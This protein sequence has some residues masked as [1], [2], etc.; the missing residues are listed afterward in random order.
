MLPV[1]DDF[2]FRLLPQQ[3][4]IRMP[5]SKTAPTMW[6]FTAVKTSKSA[7]VATSTFMFFQ[8]LFR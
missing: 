4:K 3:K 6:G 5:T 1:F 2:D 7:N 8:Q